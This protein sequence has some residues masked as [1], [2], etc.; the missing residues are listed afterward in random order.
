M[1]NAYLYHYHINIM[2]MWKASQGKMTAYKSMHDVT[3]LIDCGH[4]QL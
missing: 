2:L 1:A 3:E 4:A